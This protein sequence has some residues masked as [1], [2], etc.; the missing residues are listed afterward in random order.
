MYSFGNTNTKTFLW[1]ALS[2]LIG[3]IVC[4]AFV[5]WVGTQDLGLCFVIA[6]AL[7]NG[8]SA[9]Q[10]AILSFAKSIKPIFSSIDS[11]INSLISQREIFEQQIQNLED[12]V[13]ALDSRI[14]QI[15]R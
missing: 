9:A 6:L 2:Y 7:L 4:F 3:F 5:Y 13:A 15:E 12:K 11:N 1:V 14:Y 8:T 10:Q